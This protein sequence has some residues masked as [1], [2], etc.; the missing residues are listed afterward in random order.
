L[1]RN[2]S[3]IFHQLCATCHGTDGRGV[4]IGGKDMPAPPL[5]GSPRV[6]GDKIMNI[7]IL[8]NGLKGPIDGKNYP[9]MMASMAKNDDKWIASVI[10]YIRN[11]GDLGNNSSIVTPEEVRYVRDS[12]PKVEGGMTLQIL[13]IFKLGR[14]EKKNWS[15]E[16]NKAK[17]TDSLP[18]K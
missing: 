17:S 12:I 7:Q 1:V 8:L 13:E 11:S 9:D 2:G 10:S 16:E 5:A 14:A 6:R 18:K 3:V 15:A 4:L